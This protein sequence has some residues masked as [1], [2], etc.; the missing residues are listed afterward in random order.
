M[1]KHLYITVSFLL[2]CGS[3]LMAQDTIV[4]DLNKTKAG[5]G[6]V[7][8]YQDNAIK[9]L[10]GNRN[11]QSE[12]STET[13]TTPHSSGQ[14]QNRP[15][16]SSYKGRG[17]K[18][19][20]FSGNDQRKSKNEASSKRNLIKSR[21]PHLPVEISYEAPMWRVRVGNYAS[22]ADATDAM[23]QLRAAFP[24]FGREMYIVK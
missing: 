22:K 18:V 1:G 6:N 12:E 15:I 14:Q 8:V 5:Q 10:L 9:N 21:F 20:V 23:Q 11:N 16:D 4:D 13:T 24:A 19:L 3:F 2:F 17:Y 7:T